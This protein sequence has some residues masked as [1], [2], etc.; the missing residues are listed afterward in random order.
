MYF[1]Q[2]QIRSMATALIVS[3]LHT[4]YEKAISVGDVLTT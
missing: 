4:W 2:K 3:Y 1:A